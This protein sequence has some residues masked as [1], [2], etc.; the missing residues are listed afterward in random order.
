MM[1]MMVMITITISIAMKTA[2]LILINQRRIK[3]S[4]NKQNESQQ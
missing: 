3:E 4:K 2:K 1:M